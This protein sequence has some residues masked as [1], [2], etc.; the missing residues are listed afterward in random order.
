MHTIE[1]ARLPAAFTKG[2]QN[3]Q[4]LTIQ[5]MDPVIF[6][7]TDRVSLALAACTAVLAIFA[8]L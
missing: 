4:R 5:N 8:A 1:L 7:I 6:A 2:R 3:F